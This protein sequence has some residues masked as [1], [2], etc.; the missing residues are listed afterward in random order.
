MYPKYQILFI[1]SDQHTTPQAEKILATQ[2]ND[3][4]DGGNDNNNVLPQNMVANE[5][6]NVAN[7]NDFDFNIKNTS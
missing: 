2:V 1:G 3:D 5:F 4:E 7:H 6:E